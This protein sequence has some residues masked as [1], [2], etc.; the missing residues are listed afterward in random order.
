[1]PFEAVDISQPEQL[2]GLIERT[3]A[4]VILHSAAVSTIEGCER[5][6]ALARRVNVDASRELARQSAE[7]GS[8]FIYISTDAVFDGMRGGYTEEDP[9]TPTTEYG[10]TKLEGE[11]AVLKANPEALVARVNFYGWSPSGQRSLAEFFYGRLARGEEVRGFDDVVVSTLYVGWLVNHL[12]ALADRRAHGV[13]N[14]VSTEPI[15]KYDF[16]RRL[17][18]SFGFDPD[19]VRRAR[20]TDHLAIARGSRLDLRTE[21]MVGLLGSP[22][23][24]QQAGLDRLVADFASGR[25]RALSAFDTSQE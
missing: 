19:L 5:D 8:R 6:P 17:A 20:S 16:G 25:P 13:V 15:S 14:V 11:R 1:V 21:K 7:T 10:R 18:L 2:P 12:I 24:D 3:G 9:P 4:D 22:G 23:V